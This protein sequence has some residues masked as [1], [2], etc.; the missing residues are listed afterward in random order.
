MTVRKKKPEPPSPRVIAEIIDRMLRR[1]KAKYT[2][3]VA[4]AVQQEAP[5]RAVEDVIA[6]NGVEIEARHLVTLLK[7]A[8]Q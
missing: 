6:T 2:I 1:M 3:E 8:S 4:R 5:R 7:R